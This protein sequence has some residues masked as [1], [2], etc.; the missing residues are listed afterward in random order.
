MHTDKL[1]RDDLRVLIVDDEPDLRHILAEVLGALGGY[2]VFTAADAK[3]ALLLVDQQDK[4]FDG[5]FL[6]I[7]M[8]GMS[9]TQLCAVLRQTPGYADVPILMLTAM[10]DREH[11]QKAFIAGANDLISKPFDF[12]DLKDRFAGERFDRFRRGRLKENG[13]VGSPDAGCASREVIRSLEDAI[14]II[15]VERCIRKEAFAVYIRQSLQR[16]STP[17]HIRA[18]KIGRI[19][20]LFTRI[21]EREFQ[22][23]IQDVA[24][25][26]SKATQDS[27][28]IFAYAGNG[29]FLSSCTT[30]TSFTT[31]FFVETLRRHDSVRALESL[32]MRLTV[33]LGNEITLDGKSA[34]DVMGM[35]NRSIESAERAENNHF[36]WNSYREWLSR[37][38]S[39]GQEQ[40]N[41]EKAAYQM[42]LKEFI[43]EGHL[44]WRR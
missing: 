10:T 15:G 26:F 8:P 36:G 9:G 40:P 27:E 28:D 5:V 6:D 23:V 14:A 1:A 2:Q 11:L 24:R 12:V 38:S 42:I 18:F 4:P 34:G 25:A 35:L 41:N 44:G 21:P 39:T 3:A 32:D 22:K 37:R 7:Q 19:Y 33:F 29:V 13:G 31:S 17:I 30:E 16:Y 43:R 20:D